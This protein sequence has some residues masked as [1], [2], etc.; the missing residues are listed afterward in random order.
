MTHPTK[1]SIAL[2]WIRAE[3]GTSYLCHAAALDG[4]EHPTEEDLRRH[5]VNESENPQND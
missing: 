4:I 3:S 5:C 1:T 2:K